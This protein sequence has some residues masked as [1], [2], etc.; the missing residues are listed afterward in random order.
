MFTMGPVHTQDYDPG[1]SS[2]FPEPA[3]KQTEGGSNYMPIQNV[4][5]VGSASSPRTP[6]GWL[7]VKA[8]RVAV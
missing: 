2:A 5:G 3:A 6:G 1:C 4:T 7:Q 8:L